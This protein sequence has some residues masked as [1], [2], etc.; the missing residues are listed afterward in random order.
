VGQLRQLGLH[1]DGQRRQGGRADR[2]QELPTA[3]EM[4]IRGIGD[5]ARAPGSF[6][7]YDRVGP[8][9]ARQLDPRFEQ[10]AS[11][12]AV[13]IRAALRRTRC[14]VVTILYVD[15][16]HFSCYISLWTAYTKRFTA[17]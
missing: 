12:V 1:R 8:A 14:R 3:G 6:A 11:E 4:P 17:T 9:G 13:A 7:Q 10:R 2:L 15:T 16:V 5:H